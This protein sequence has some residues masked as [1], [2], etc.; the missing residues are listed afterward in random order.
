MT[1]KAIGR[2]HGEMFAR[3]ILIVAIAGLL[4]GTGVLIVVMV[5][6]MG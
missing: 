6:G 2:I 3:V 5:R 4:I 1:D